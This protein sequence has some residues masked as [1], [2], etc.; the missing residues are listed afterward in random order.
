MR[1]GKHHRAEITGINKTE[2]NGCTAFTFW[3]I[4]FNWKIR[5]QRRVPK[6]RRAC[7]KTVRIEI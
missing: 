7:E 4:I 2:D 6:A 1:K 3:K 5:S